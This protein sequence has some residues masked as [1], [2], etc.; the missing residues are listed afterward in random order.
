MLRFYFHPCLDLGKNICFLETPIW[1]HIMG[2][3][4]M[5]ARARAVK[6]EQPEV[7]DGP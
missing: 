4:V 7:S 6:K 1:D 2:N 3:Q 5:A